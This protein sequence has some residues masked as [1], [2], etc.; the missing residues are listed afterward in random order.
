MKKFNLNDAKVYVSTYKKYNEGSLSGGWINI[1]DYSDKE[2]F[3]EA[4][5]E[6][7]KDEEDA[8]FMFQDYENIPENLISESWISGNFFTLR[9]AVEDLGDTEQEAFF[10]WCN[11]KSRDLSEDDA[12]DLVRDFQDEYQ[13]QY[14]DEEDFAYQ[15]VGECY[16]L[17]ELAKNYF[18]YEKFARDLFM[19]DYCFDDGFVF[20]R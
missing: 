8:E 2:G 3:Y 16:D 10:V 14:D 15:I 1:S 19:C 18:D 6:L 12:D 13:G 11:Y 9:D 7:H 5:R 20:Q 4:C 17:P